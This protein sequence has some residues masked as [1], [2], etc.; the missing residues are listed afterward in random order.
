LTAA[1]EPPLSGWWL[2]AAAFMVDS[3]VLLV[4]GV[5][6]FFL[7]WA[8]VAGPGL[9]AAIAWGATEYLI[10]GLVYAPLLM[11]RHGAHNGQTLGKQLTEI[12]VVRD[13]DARPIGY[14]KA[15]HREWFA[16]TLLFQVLGVALTGGLAT[17]LD[18]LQ[19]LWDE[20]NRAVHD[21][22]ASTLVVRVVKKDQSLRQAWPERSREP[23]S[24]G[25]REPA[26]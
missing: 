10:R 26:T 12:R 6:L 17:L 2:R 7:L 1:R 9:A 15:V 16:K 11:R 5:V 13:G 20:R 22:V 4:V 19:P 25:P 23:A 8:T 3:L 21:M 14:G 18:Y 24:V